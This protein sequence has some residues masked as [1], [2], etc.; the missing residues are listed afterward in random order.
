MHA[1]EERTRSFFI[2]NIISVTKVNWVFY[3]PKCY[4]S[5]N[6]KLACEIF[7]TCEFFVTLSA[8]DLRSAANYYI[9]A[10]RELAIPSLGEFKEV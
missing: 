6:C 10:S 2:Q 8:G 5:I 7:E 1:K 3:Y 9:K 4:I